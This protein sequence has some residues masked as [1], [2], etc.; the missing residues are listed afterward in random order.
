MKAIKD[1]TRLRID[2]GPDSATGSYEVY[3][4]HWRRNKWRKAVVVM[5]RGTRQRVVVDAKRG[6]YRAVLPAYG[7]V[8]Q[9]VSNAVRL[10]R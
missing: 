10:R 4:Q 3:V 1:K 5:T 8:A 2:V 7:G 9:V 6:R